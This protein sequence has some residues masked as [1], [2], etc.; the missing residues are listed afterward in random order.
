MLTEEFKYT[1]KEFI[2]RRE[3]PRTIIID[4]TKTFKAAS[5]WLKTIVHD[6]D[7]FN[8]FSLQRTEWKFDM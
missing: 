1:L 5:N 8:F 4:N 2:E 6:E 3:T 7:F